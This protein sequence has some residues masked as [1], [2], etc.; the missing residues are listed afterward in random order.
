MIDRMTETR[1]SFPLCLNE[2][3]KT[4]QR[5]HHCLNSTRCVELGHQSL[6]SV[7]QSISLPH[8]FNPFPTLH[9]LW[10]WTARSLIQTIM[11]SMVCFFY[12]IRTEREPIPCFCHSVYLSF[13]VIQ[14]F[15]NS[16]QERKR[17]RPK[18]R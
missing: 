16:I 1:E 6:V 2:M 8:F 10:N 5:S 15:P 18:D 7:V 4:K 9:I 13:F 3:D 11:T 14:P 12:S 17:D